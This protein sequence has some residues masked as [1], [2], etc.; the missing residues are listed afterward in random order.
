MLRLRILSLLLPAC[1]LAAPAQPPARHQPV[2]V[3]FGDSLT[4]GYGAPQGQSYPD[5]LES[6]LIEQGLHTRIVNR[7]VSGATS[8]DALGQ[9]PDVLALHPDIAVVEF[10]ANDG[11]R[12]APAS[13]IA[14]NMSTII[15][16]LQRA[17]VRVILAG[18]YMPPNYGPDYVRQ[19]D[20][21]YPALARKYK[22]PLLP[23]LLKDVYGVPGMMSGDGIHP[24]G[25]GYQVVARN[26]LSV[27]LPLLHK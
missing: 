4:A 6:D 19:F 27:L 2:I 12:G 15:E 11:L 26:V 9:L 14:A 23:F 8:K 3:C 21:I 7:G 22:V 20:A 25:E 18:I 10:G 1:L 17:H 16:A 13:L 24:N 5:F